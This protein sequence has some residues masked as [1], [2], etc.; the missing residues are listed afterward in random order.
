MSRGPG[1]L[2]GAFLESGVVSFEAVD[3]PVVDYTD[4]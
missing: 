2:V 1:H 3:R 4:E